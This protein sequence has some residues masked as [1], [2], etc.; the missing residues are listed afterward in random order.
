MLPGLGLLGLAMFPWGLL[1][2]R[3][4]ARLSERTGRP[5]TIGAMERVDTISFHPHLRFKAIRWPQPTWVEPGAKAGLD[6]LARI[7]QA[8]VQLSVWSLLSGNMALERADLKGALLSFYRNAQGRRN[9][10]NGQSNAGGHPALLRVLHITDSRLRYLDD[11]RDRSLD[12]AITSDRASLRV[13]GQGLVMG[14]PVQIKAQGAAIV[15]GQAHAAWPYQLTIES[16][17][18]GFAIKGTMPRPLD[19]AHLQGEAQG[20]ATDLKLLDAI[21]EAGLP[22]TQ[23]V[24]LTA[25]IRRNRPDWVID[26]LLGTVGRSDIAGHATIVKRQGRSRIT[27]ALFA[28]R[29]DFND[30]SSDAGK[31]R[32]AALKARLGPRLLPGSAIDLKHVVH[33]DGALDLRVDHLLWPGPSPFRSMSA[34]LSLERSRLAISPL[35]LGLTHGTFAGSL[36]I[37]QSKP[38]Q[39]DPQLTVNLAM[40]GAR[41]MDF[42][43]P[44]QIDGSLVGNMAM[45]GYGHTV[46]AALGAGSGTV[47][48]VGRDGQIPARTA[49][50]LGQDVGGGLTSG[51]QDMAS[52]RCMVMRLD[53]RHGL[54]RPAPILIDTSR[55]QTSVWGTLNLSDE[56]LALTLKGAPKGKALLRL[57]G[58]IPIAGTIKQP[59]IKVPPHAKSLGGILGMVGAAITGKQGPRAQDADCDALAA[60][61]LR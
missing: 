14:H 17:A 57:P 44:A 2:G 49:A 27:G 6:D 8:D 47:A 24:Q 45:S 38:G 25:Q 30:L 43:P 31:A 61:A 58:A 39:R 40:R 42:F 35:T 15:E 22:G 51:K 9:W 10:S 60:Q 59:D 5:V 20:H 34:H 56:R 4:E 29:F 12:V 46:R 7:D 1:K 23:P 36:R 26:H 54:A 18:V 48:L 21:I 19:L 33:T 41:L 28:N 11:K 50:L 13:E 55:G 32:G 52:L 53:V 16:P 37:D 3:I